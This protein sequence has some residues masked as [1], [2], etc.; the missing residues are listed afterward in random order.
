[1]VVLLHFICLYLEYFF[2]I[3]SAL[4]PRD[5]QQVFTSVEDMKRFSVLHS[6]FECPDGSKCLTWGSEFF[7]DG[8]M[9][10][11]EDKQ[12]SLF[13]QLVSLQNYIWRRPLMDLELD[14]KCFYSEIKLDLKLIT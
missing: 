9:A 11:Q 1:M 2:G 5:S 12:I 6:D 8:H 14:C 3:K 10:S 7:M 4:Q 13:P